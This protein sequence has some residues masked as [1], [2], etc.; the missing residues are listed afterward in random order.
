MTAV[1]AIV[2]LV[3]SLASLAFGVYQ[4]R[5][6]QLVRKN[7]R[8]TSL[9]RCAQD[10]RRKSED[11]KHLIGCTDHVDDCEELLSKVND[12]VDETVPR[13]ALSKNRSLEELFEIE[14]HLLSLELE[15]DLLH[16]QV[17][18]VRRFNEEVREYESRKAVR[19]EL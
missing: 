18:E 3:L 13:L 6:L 9:V 4:Y 17:L 14:Q 12:F 5:I 2:A 16:K 8:A 10:L 1:T 11:L 15:I 7:E 19:N